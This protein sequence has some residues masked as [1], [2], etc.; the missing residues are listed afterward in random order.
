MTAA[1]FPGSGFDWWYGRGVWM[2]GE[3]G[4]H[5]QHLAERHPDWGPD[6]GEDCDDYGLPPCRDDWAWIAH[7]V[8]ASPSALPV[9]WVQP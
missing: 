8:K 3:D 2:L 4:D 9:L 1:T 7:S 6:C 5:A